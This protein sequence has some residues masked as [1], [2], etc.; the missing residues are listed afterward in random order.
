MINYSEREEWAWTAP[1][2]AGHKGALHPG[3]NSE[4][5]TSRE[6]AAGELT[7]PSDEGLYDAG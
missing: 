5:H 2:R 7:S 1:M 4:N 6:P 3:K